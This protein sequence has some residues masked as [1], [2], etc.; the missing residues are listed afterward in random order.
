MKVLFLQNI[1]GIAGSE[2]YFLALIPSLIKKGIEV[3][4]CCVIKQKKKDQ[5]APF[6]QLLKDKKIPFSLIYC[7]SYGSPLNLFRINRRVKKYGANILHCHLIYADVWGAAIKQLFNKT[8]T[9]VSTKHGYHETTYVKYCMKPQHLPKNLYYYLF[10]YSHKHINASYACS[11]GLFEFYTKANLI[12]PSEMNV[13][14]HGFDYPEIEP[15]DEKYRYSSQQIIITGRLIERKGHHFL[16]SIMPKLI[17]EYPGICLVIL[18]SGEL[19]ADLKQ[20]VELLDVSSHIKFKGFQSDVAGFLQSSDIMLV[21]SY[22]EG[23]PLVIFEAFNA[24]TPVITFD[25]IGSNELVEHQKTGLVV[26][27]FDTDLLAESIS[28]I[29]E[30]DLVAKQLTKNAYATLKSKFSLE[31]MTEDTIQFYN[32]T[33]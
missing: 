19:E 9:V 24:K 6:I 31:R 32:R 20:Q 33:I 14:Q 26:P 28:F 23:L 3:E 1:D 21:T 15:C 25:T 11:N 29:F 27:A 8:I 5:A 12:E 10:K 2:K 16:I 13:V 18:G 7:Q 17:K 22:S 30:N 4:M